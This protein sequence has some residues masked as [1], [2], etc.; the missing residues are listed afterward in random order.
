MEELYPSFS[1]YIMPVLSGGTATQAG[2][3]IW[4]A[5]YWDRIIPVIEARLAEHGEKFIAG[6]SRPTIADF[7]VFHSQIATLYNPVTPVPPPILNT[8]N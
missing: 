7:K 5:E 1:S 6:T 3:A 8:L 4:F 2:G